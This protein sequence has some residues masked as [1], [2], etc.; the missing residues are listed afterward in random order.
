TSLR[1]HPNILIPCV[2]R[3]QGA[4]C[5]Q[6][7]LRV[8]SSW[9]APAP[10]A[11]PGCIDD[12]LLIAC[13]GGGGAYEAARQQ[14][15]SRRARLKLVNRLAID[16]RLSIRIGGNVAFTGNTS[17]QLPPGADSNAVAA[18]REVEEYVS[19]YRPPALSLLDP[20]GCAPSRRTGPLASRRKCERRRRPEGRGGAAA[21]RRA[22]AVAA[23]RRLRGGQR[24]GRGRPARVLSAAPDGAGGPVGGRLPADRGRGLPAPGRAPGAPLRRAAHLRL[25]D[26]A[27]PGGGAGPAER[28]AAR[29]ALRRHGRLRRPALTQR[30]CHITAERL[31]AS[32]ARSLG[33]AAA[34]G[35]AAAAGAPDGLARLWEADAGRLLRGLLLSEHCREFCAGG[36]AG[37]VALPLGQTFPDVQVELF[38]DWMDR[39]DQGRSLQRSGLHVRFQR[40]T[41]MQQRYIDLCKG[42]DSYIKF[43]SLVGHFKRLANIDG[44]AG[45]YS[46]RDA[47]HHLLQEIETVAMTIAQSAA[48]IMEDVKKQ[49]TDLC[50]RHGGGSRGSDDHARWIERLTMI[51]ELEQR[52]SL[53]RLL[54]LVQ[55][56]RHRSSEARLPSLRSSARRN[57]EQILSDSASEGF[58]ARCAEE[59]PALAGGGLDC[60]R[61]GAPVVQD[62]AP[63]PA[64]SVEWHFRFQASEVP[65]ELQESL[66]RAAE[67]PEAA[68]SAGAAGPEASSA[69]LG[70]TV[71]KLNSGAIQG[72][73]PMFTL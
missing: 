38:H 1:R 45:M 23:P 63:A 39:A 42:V 73:V 19:A 28:P 52:V 47:L 56:L 35:P 18:L 25:A 13:I 67:P 49:V 70:N 44:D 16:N 48:N 36:A 32:A 20:T 14:D 43:L 50:L 41:D 22:E 24:G 11:M 37:A 59:P 12:I 3:P 6:R 51:D 68:G 72:R 33:A 10:R 5:A 40:D 62:G 7:N 15:R 26:G 8:D 53:Q 29:A 2:R 54:T 66:G 65:M 64:W 57:L 46:V 9:R 71:E 61:A 58:R 17:S 69:R 21:L 34:A 30:F 4:S 31:R 55:E 27:A 60:L